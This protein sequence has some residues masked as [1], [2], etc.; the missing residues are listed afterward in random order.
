MYNQL[1]EH[2]NELN[3]E[4]ESSNVHVSEDHDDVS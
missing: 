2:W 1:K 3:L 4:P